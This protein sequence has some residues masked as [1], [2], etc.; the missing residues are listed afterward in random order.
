MV[1]IIVISIA[2]ILS[3]F[4][5]LGYFGRVSIQ[6]RDG[7]LEKNGYFVGRTV[8]EAQ[9][10][11]GS[12]SRQYSRWGGRVDYVW[13]AGSSSVL[14]ISNEQGK[15]VDYCP[16]RKGKKFVLHYFEQNRDAIV[17]K[18][19]WDIKRDLG[20]SNEYVSFDFGEACDTWKAAKRTLIEVWSKGDTC[21]NLV[22]KKI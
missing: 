7:L 6:K 13:G 21:T 14:L 17:G 22:F 10:A 12:Y 11:L 18:K 15:I 4:V 20:E 19:V 9:A 2:V 3:A 5:V 8:E 16:G 1:A